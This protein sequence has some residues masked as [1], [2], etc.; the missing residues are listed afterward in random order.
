MYSQKWN[1]LVV[2]DDADVLSISRLAMKNI[3]IYGVPVRIHTA[4]SK[5]QAI[6]L[7]RTTLTSQ[8]G[9]SQVAVA[10]IDIVMETDHAGLELCQYLREDLNNRSTQI[11]VRTGQPGIVPER[12]IVDR[13]EINGYLSKTEA[14][15]DKLWSV[16][17]SG[18]RE[19]GFV[20]LS[21]TNAE[22][23]HALI[24]V[25][26]S[27]EGMLEVIRDSR[28]GM[29]TDEKGRKLS[30]IDIKTCYFID[31]KVVDA[32]GMEEQ[33]AV[34][35]RERLIRAEGVKLNAEGDRYVADDGHFLI[36]IAASRTCTP[37]TYVSKAAAA[38]PDLWLRLIHGHLRA[39]SALWKKSASYSSNRI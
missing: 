8:S 5:A 14:T 17:K 36:D 18:I 12:T 15:E 29:Q 23:L 28:T 13:Y 26:D 2:D 1:I 24:Q 30:D 22:L 4:S 9:V 33:E 37:V 32:G 38:P 10:L 19:Y 16:V 27:R 20:K 31:G 39:F 3:A 6:E 11:Y 21:Q 7:L 35:Q 34:A 25:A